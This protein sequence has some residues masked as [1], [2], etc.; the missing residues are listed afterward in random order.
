MSRVTYANTP[1][2]AAQATLRETDQVRVVTAEEEGMGVNALPNGVYGFTYSPALPN[3]PLFAQR[4]YRSYET[5]KLATGEAFIIGFASADVAQQVTASPVEITVVIQPEPDEQSQTLVKI[6]YARIRKHGQYA[7]PN[8]DGRM[9]RTWVGSSRGGGGTGLV[10]VVAEPIAGAARVDGGRFLSITAS[11]PRGGETLF[12]SQPVELQS[13]MPPLRLSF[14]ADPGALEVRILLADSEGQ[15]IDRE[16][17]TLEMPD[18][19]G[20]M[21]AIGTPRFYRPRTVREFQTLAADPNAMPLTTRDFA[22]TDRLLVRV[23][24][25]AAGGGLAAPTAAV[26]SRSGRKMFDLQVA[27]SAAAGA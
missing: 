17:R 11:R 3:A 22:R 26:L 1:A 4:R 23:D 27:Q 25:L 9:V 14:E 18:Y 24:A 13:G 6:P 21:A 5:H 7:A 19:S 2:T 16:T 20:G 15:T 8:Q 10:T 12:E